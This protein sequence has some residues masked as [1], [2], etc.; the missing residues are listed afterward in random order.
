MRSTRANI[1]SL[2]AA[3]AAIE[4]RSCARSLSSLPLRAASMSAYSCRPW[5]SHG[6]ALAE[7]TGQH[8]KK[9]CRRSAAQ[10]KDWNRDDLIL[11]RQEKGINPF[12]MF[13]IPQAGSNLRQICQRDKPPAVHGDAGFR[14]RKPIEIVAGLRFEAEITTDQHESWPPRSIL[15]MLVD[16]PLED[17]RYLGEPTLFTAYREHLHA[18]DTRCEIRVSVLRHLQRV[19]RLVLRLSKVTD[20]YGPHRLRPRNAPLV[21]KV[22]STGGNLPI[23]LQRALET[24]HLADLQVAGKTSGACMTNGVRIAENFRDLPEFQQYAFTLR[25]SVRSQR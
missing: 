17:R 21:D 22:L 23:P 14:F 15:R 19:A 18:V 7:S 2:L 11:E 3:A 1:L 13:D 20:E 10:R 4:S 12:G 16:K 6:H 8:A 24:V 25:K 9:P 5:A